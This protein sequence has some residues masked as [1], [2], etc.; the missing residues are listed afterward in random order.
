MDNANIKKIGVFTLCAMLPMMAIGLF[1]HYGDAG[2]TVNNVAVLCS[3]FTPLL[4]VAFTQQLFKEPVLKGL[5]IN[6]KFSYCWVMGWLLMA[7][8]S[9]AVLGMSLLV[10][11]AHLSTQVL[12]QITSDAPIKPGMWGF[13]GVTLVNGLLTGATLNAVAAFGE[14]VGWRGF[15]VKELAGVKFL[16]A[17]LWIGVLWG[18]WHFPLILNG[19]N[20]PDHPVAGVFMMVLMCV[21]ASPIFLYFRLKGRSVILSAII[22][23]TFNAVLP[24]A[25][26]LVQ[27]V[28]DLMIGVAGVAGI[29]TMLLL[30]AAIFIYDRYISRENLFLRPLQP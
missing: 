15:L 8:L 14:E 18:L 5:G 25:N 16:W 19:H 6:F 23:G 3:M 2:E 7:L 4:S 30:D 9:L 20:Y 17:A 10:P 21:S 29:A 11:G 13:V 26:V 12:D 28:N 24:L 1:L 22:H 27:P